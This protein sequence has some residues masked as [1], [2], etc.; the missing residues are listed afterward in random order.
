MTFF[1]YQYAIDMPTNYKAL[2]TTRLDSEIDRLKNMGLIKENGKIETSELGLRCAEE[3]IAPE[4]ALILYNALKSNELKINKPLIMRISLKVL[5]IF[6]A[7]R[8]IPFWYMPPNLEVRF[9]S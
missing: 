9:R 4:T 3:L 1:G 8:L 6:V 2:V 7:V 5:S